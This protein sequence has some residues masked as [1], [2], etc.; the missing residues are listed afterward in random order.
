M[1]IH[2]PFWQR[3]LLSSITSEGKKEMD[4]GDTLKRPLFYDS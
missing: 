2:A 1:E 3:L 4:L